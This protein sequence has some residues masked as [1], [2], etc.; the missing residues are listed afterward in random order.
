MTGVAVVAAL[1][2]ALS[3]PYAATA[4]TRSST[5]FSEIRQEGSEVRYEL[6]LE[7][8]VLA[9]VTGLGP[10]A[11]DAPSDAAR[12]RELR[13]AR[14]RVAGYLQPRARV[15]LDGV[16][17]EGS[18]LETAVERRERTAYAALSLAYACPG[19]P[20]GSYT[21]VYGVFDAG[22]GVVDDHTSMAD[23]SLGGEHGRFVFDGSHRELDAGDAG[24][25][26]SA[27]RFVALGVE[28][29]LEG[30][31][32]VLFVVALVLG[33][34]GLVGVLKVAT[35]FTVAHSLTLAL[36]VLGWVDV[37]AEVV[38][39]LIALSIA[40]VA[41]ENVLGGESRH[42]LA[43]VFGFGLLHGLGFASTL[44]FTEDVGW[45][46]ISSLLSFN[47]G[48]EI[49]QA[50]II[51]LLFPLLLALRRFAWSSVAHVG[52]TAAIGGLAFVWFFERMTA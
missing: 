21:V 43:V 14:E 26:S 5:G 23:Y 41:A 33:A 6:L 25:L 27:R 13:A 15:S 45:P 38:E 35:A 34:R 39:P 2:A 24:A 48:V 9:M 18:L 36:A 37:P 40:Y 7:Y 52:A 19:S 47:V 31:D 8:E 46:L 1:I 3:L 10:R 49:G 28:H 16:A 17:C 11:I 29:I 32:H 30:I 4:H 51:A 50:L 12:A 42:R 44:S 22:G 20:S